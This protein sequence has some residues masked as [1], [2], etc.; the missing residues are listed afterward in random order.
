MCKT[1]FS[2]NDKRRQ[3][4]SFM[5]DQSQSGTFLFWIEAPRKAPLHSKLVFSEAELIC[6]LK[7]RHKAPGERGGRT[8]HFH[9]NSTSPPKVYGC[10]YIPRHGWCK[11]YLQVNVRAPFILSQE[12]ARRMIKRG[13]GGKI[14]TVSSTASKFA[15]HDHAAYCTSKF[16]VNGLNSVRVFLSW[17]S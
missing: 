5:R 1:T 9:L 4:V 13:K 7:M 11:Q 10:W 2:Y 15:L 8:H 14:V 12:C 17:R 6:Y 3:G 16:A